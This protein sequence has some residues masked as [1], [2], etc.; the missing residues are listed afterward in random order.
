MASVKRTW[1]NSSVIESPEKSAIYT[2]TDTTLSTLKIYFRCL[3][4]I[5]KV[6]YTQFKLSYFATVS[7]A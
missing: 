4:R 7:S 5:L 1:I 6:D 3:I 2:S